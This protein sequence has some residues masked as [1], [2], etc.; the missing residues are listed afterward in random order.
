MRKNCNSRKEIRKARNEFRQVEKEYNNRIKKQ[1]YF[2][3]TYT[4][5]L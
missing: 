1:N 4:N 5:N 2:L 3:V